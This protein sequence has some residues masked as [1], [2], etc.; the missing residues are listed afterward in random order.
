[1]L[2]EQKIA[3]AQADIC[4]RAVSS[5][6]GLPERACAFIGVL[7]TV[8]VIPG[9]VEWVGKK[10]IK[11][12][13]KVCGHCITGEVAVWRRSSCK[14]LACHCRATI[15]V[16]N[17]HVREKSTINDTSTVKRRSPGR[18]KTGCRGADVSGRRDD[19]DALGVL[20]QSEVHNLII[21]YSLYI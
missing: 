4:P 16:T 3:R 6:V 20:R 18:T 5:R 14:L 7:E 19:V 21:D 1:V 11:G 8:A 17:E 2:F 12:M 15:R 10:A 13:R 9:A